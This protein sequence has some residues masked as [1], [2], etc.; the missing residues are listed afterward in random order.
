MKVKLEAVWLDLGGASKLCQKISGALLIFGK[1]GVLHF[2]EFYRS[3]MS[4]MGFVGEV[5]N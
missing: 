1:I 5:Q 2:Y 3:F 4:F